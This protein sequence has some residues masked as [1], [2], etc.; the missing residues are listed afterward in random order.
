MCNGLFASFWN[1][2]VNS[3][4]SNCWRPFHCQYPTKILTIIS[5]WMWCRYAQNPRFY[6][7]RLSRPWV[8][9]IKLQLCRFFSFPFWTLNLLTQFFQIRLKKTNVT[10]LTRYPLFS[11]IFTSFGIKHVLLLFCIA[12]SLINQALSTFAIIISLWTNFN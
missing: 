9:I 10:P 11:D 12:Y 5:L 1:Y 3:A 6:T 4:Y 7:D 2:K 8:G